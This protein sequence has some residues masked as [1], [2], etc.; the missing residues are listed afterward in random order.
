M[1]I[2]L[3]LEPENII[4]RKKN[5][6][7]REKIEEKK[8]RICRL[9]FFLSDRSQVEILSWHGIPQNIHLGKMLKCILKINNTYLYNYPSF[10]TKHIFI[11]LLLCLRMKATEKQNAI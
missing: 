1:K 10:D 5:Q 2:Q 11:M 8:F 3:F 6:Q 7:T 4:W 9:F